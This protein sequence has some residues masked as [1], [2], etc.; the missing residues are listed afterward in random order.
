MRKGLQGAC[1]VFGVALALGQAPTYAASDA[2]RLKYRSK[3]SPC[4][5]ASGMS[6]ADISRAMAGLDRLQSAEP[7]PGPGDTKDSEADKRRSADEE[8]K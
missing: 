5:C 6:E 4:A 1:I 2:P 3:G 8:L 7:Q